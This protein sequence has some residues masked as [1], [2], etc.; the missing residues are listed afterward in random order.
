V[1]P[2]G[3]RCPNPA[4]LLSGPRFAELLAWADAHYDQILVDCPPVL[5]VSDA[6]IVGRLVDGAILVVRPDKNHRRVVMR[7]VDSF[8]ATECHL[9]GVVANGIAPGGEG[10]GYGYGYGYEYGYGHDEEVAEE[11]SVPSMAPPVPPV[12]SY[13]TPEVPEAPAPP[14]RPRKAA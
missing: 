14:I 6:Q 7:A 2:A 8:Q 5:A 1:L 9:L 12:V 10:Y 11:N 3:I 4:E 13:E